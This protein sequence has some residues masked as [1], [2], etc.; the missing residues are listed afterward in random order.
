MTGPAE[1][2]LEFVAAEVRRIMAAVKRHQNGDRRRA[3]GL[4]MAT[5]TLSACSTVL[6]GVR[7][8]DPGRQVLLDVALGIS[9]L[10]T[11]LAAWDAFFSH[12]SLW[13]QASQTVLRLESLDRDI[14]FYSKGLTDGPASDQVREFL[15]RLDEILREH[16]DGWAKLRRREPDA[17]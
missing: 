4:Q 6:L 12:R 1:A 11:V 17:A 15:E 2:Q 9:A 10:I 13:I 7:V 14:T 16:H 5:V 8:G 3:F